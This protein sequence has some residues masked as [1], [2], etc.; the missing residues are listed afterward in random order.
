ML[1]YL[2]AALLPGCS[3]GSPADG[4]EDSPPDDAA[5]IES[6]DGL[7]DLPEDDAEAILDDGP[8]ED[9]APGD[10]EEDGDLD[11][12]EEL[13]GPPEYCREW[14]GLSNFDLVMAVHAYLHETY[15]PIEARPN[16]AGVPDRYTTARAMMFVEVEWVIEHEGGQDGVE[17]LYTGTF[18]P[19]PEGEEPNDAVVNC[20]H[21]LPR[22][23]MDADRASL[24]F[25]HQES[26]IHNLFPVLPGVNS[27]RGSF[28]FGIPV[29][30]LTRFADPADETQF[31]LV[32]L[33]AEGRRVFQPRALRQGDVA[34]VVFYF[35]LRWGKDIPGFEEAVLRAW[36]EE[37]PVDDRE[38]QRNELIALQ[39]G[40]RNPF[41]DCPGLP[42]MIDDFAAFEIL[43]TN[44][45]LPPP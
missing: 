8:G 23:A 40:D 12:E 42:G 28:P 39:Q 20:E 11:A 29:S 2:A 6:E 36:Y 17:C 31:A 13:H 5:V 7:P 45:T 19:L 3:S 24:L 15:I 18:T 37:D 38:R 35:S 25:S 44:E 22:S 34:R 33:D 21:V 41:V 43:D 32:G 9:P 4:G 30:D 1:A 14:E 10:G 16:T 27:S 26:D